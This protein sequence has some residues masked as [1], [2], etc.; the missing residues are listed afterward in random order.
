MTGLDFEGAVIGPQVDRG[1]NAGNTTFE[2]LRT[3]SNSFDFF[4]N[5]NPPFLQPPSPQ[6]RI[7]DPHTFSSIRIT[8][9]TSP[10]IDRK[11]REL[12]R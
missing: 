9:E 11:R 1:S 3:I 4:D 12:W 6:L 5:S 8:M 2:N 10:E 7:Q